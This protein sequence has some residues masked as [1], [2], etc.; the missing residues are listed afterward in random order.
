M[1]SLE[2]LGNPVQARVVPAAVERLVAAQVSMVSAIYRYIADAERLEDD[3][4]YYRYLA[5]ADGL[6]AYG[7]VV[8]LRGRLKTVVHADTVRIPLERVLGRFGKRAQLTTLLAREEVGAWTSVLAEWCLKIDGTMLGAFEAH[9]LPTFGTSPSAA[10][11]RVK[12]HLAE[13]MLPYDLHVLRARAEGCGAAAAVDA[14]TGG[15][16]KGVSA[17]VPAAVP[18]LG[19]AVPDEERTAY[20]REQLRP[21]SV[22]AESVGDPEPGDAWLIA[23]DPEPTIEHTDAAFIACKV[24]A[25]AAGRALRASARNVSLEACRAV[26]GEPTHMTTTEGGLP[27][28]LYAVRMGDALV[29]IEGVE[30]RAT[31]VMLLGDPRLPVLAFDRLVSLLRD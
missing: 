22:V 10:L 5:E 25:A 4:E 1:D 30:V 14:F 11:C 13:P 2:F 3:T 15:H 6:P 21:W 31:N 29:V 16:T 20:L 28:W 7:A 23:P 27:G 17:V 12:F 19:S 26:L 18:Y 24:C 8:H 9:E